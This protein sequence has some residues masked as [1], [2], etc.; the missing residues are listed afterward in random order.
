MRPT[1]PPTD[2]WADDRIVV[3]RS[4][5][6]GQG[7][8][9]GHDI[10]YGT[11]VL[12]LGGRLVTGAELGQLIAAAD[13]DAEAPYVDTVTIYED[14][15]LVLPPATIVHFGNHSCDPNL[16]HVGSYELATRR[17]VRAGEE[18]TLDYGTNSGAHGFA[19]ECRCGSGLCRGRVT[20][21]DWRLPELRARYNDHWTPALQQRVDRL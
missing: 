1:P 17:A 21:E 18:L 15:E 14:A 5:I 11:V 2:V 8:I 19:M 9:A 6:E 3:D 16:W 20:S 7:L 4:A 10:G 13:R 12:R